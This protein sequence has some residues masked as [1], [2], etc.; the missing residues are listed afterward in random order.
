MSGIVQ[1]APLPNHKDSHDTRV[2]LSARLR[3]PNPVPHALVGSLRKND[4]DG[5][6]NV[7]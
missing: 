7:I 5:C 2:R 4:V 3:L 1:N 6:E